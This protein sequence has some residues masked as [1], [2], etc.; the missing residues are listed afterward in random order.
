MKRDVG[1]FR[2]LMDNLSKRLT[3]RGLNEFLEDRFGEIKPGD[4]VL[5]IGAGGDINSRLARHARR[6]G[7]RMVTLDVDPARGPDLVGDVC[8]HDLGASTFDVVV[9]GEVLE[10]VRRPDQALDNLR[11]CL[12]EGGTLVLTTPFLFPLHNRPVDYYRFTRY[13]LEYLLRDFR[14]VTVS[15]RNTWAEAINNLL[16]RVYHEAGL[17]P[18][19]LGPFLLA[20]ACLNRPLVIL[21]GWLTPGD[22]L[23]TGYN[24]R[25]RK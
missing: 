20:W 1:R 6:A 18:R 2:R 9:M 21:L 12:V 24:A 5:S 22:G 10:H 4:R 14:E 16:A 7:F 19:I 17:W 11:G 13:G 15:E 3:R 8:T 23:T 25:A